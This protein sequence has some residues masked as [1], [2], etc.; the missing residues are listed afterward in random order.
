[1]KTE[2]Y[3]MANQVGEFRGAS[4]NISGEG[5]AG[6]HFMAKATSD[7]EYAEWV[8]EA[9]KSSASLDLTS[10][11]ELAKPSSYNPVALYQ[12]KDEKLFEQVMMKYMHPTPKE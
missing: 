7:E 1:M 8:A 2:L 4:A 11:N 12:L 9:T 6:M 3:L 10:Y 5:F